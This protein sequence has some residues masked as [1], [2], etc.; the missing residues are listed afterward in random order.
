MEFAIPI[1][2]FDPNN[3]K[4]GQ[5]RSGPF[6]KIIPF[7][8]QDNQVVFNSLIFILEPM[9]VV[10]IDWDKNQLILEEGETMSFM[11]KLEQ[12]QKNVNM[13][14]AENYTKW[15]SEN[16]MPES[17]ILNPVQPWLKNRR[18]TLYLSS[19]P[20]NL[21]FYS[22]SNKEILSDK[23]LKPGDMIRAT[24][25]LHGISLQMSH[26]DVW[27]GRSRIQHNMMELYKVSH[28]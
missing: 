17:G 20:K 28:D 15:L 23:T 3:I 24:V 16:E 1:S 13:S 4:W 2:R 22:D 7:G 14:I 11:T 5:P 25:K 19:E 27:T 12:F 9:R 18:I 6:R 10:G 8:Y 26:L 21:T